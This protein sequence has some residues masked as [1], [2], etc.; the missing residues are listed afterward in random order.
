MSGLQIIY[1]GECPFCAHY[2]KVTRL[3]HAV[4]NVRLIDARSGDPLVRDVQD[5][6]YDLNAG[7]LA[8]YEGRDYFGPDCMHLLALLSNR[9]GVLNAVISRL[10]ENRGIAAALYPVLRACRNATLRVLGREPIS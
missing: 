7:M 4:G 3:K 6:G 9:S 2:V 5:R 8:I 1:D 10:F